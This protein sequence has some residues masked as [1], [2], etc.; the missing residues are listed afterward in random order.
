VNN[1]AH[2]HLLVF[3]FSALGDVVMTIQVIRQ[4][5]NQHSNLSVTFVSEKKF[6][7][8]FNNI[9]RLDFFGADIRAEYSGLKGIYNLYLKLKKSHRQSL[10]ADLHD[11]LRTKILNSFFKISGYTIATI[12][13]GRKEKKELTRKENKKLIQ[14]KTTSQRYA[15]VFEK[16]GYPIKLNSSLQK[17]KLLYNSVVVQLLGENGNFR[18]GIA[19]FARHKEKMY[20]L[21]KM[22][23]V[24]KALSE[25]GFKLFLL[26]GGAK[27]IEVLE[28]WENKYPGT[29]N[30][31]GEL[32]LNEELMLISHLDLMISMDSANMH[33]ASLYGVPVISI[34]G[35]THP[36]AGFYGFGQSHDNIIQTEL[37]CR[38]CSVFG[39]KKCHRGD[40]ACLQ[41]IKPEFIIE[42]VEKMLYKT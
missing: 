14:L 27:E 4:L 34:W 3:R 29:L 37:A 7:P 35:A 42:K 15:D 5:L 1:T 2:K 11:V 38:P 18:I 28:Q 39:N 6:E 26:G 10:I 16:L 36:F 13:K 9:D 17:V 8:L 20:P 19:P 31:A 23:S 25:K 32:P 12:D 41:M 24:V 22:E 33:L 40:W 30:I 21:D